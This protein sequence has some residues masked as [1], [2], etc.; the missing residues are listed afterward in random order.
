MDTINP[1]PQKIWTVFSDFKKWTGEPYHT[2]HPPPNSCVCDLVLK[3]VQD[4]SEPVPQMAY[5]WFVA[6]RKKATDGKTVKPII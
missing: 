1:F 5:K 6:R 3:K 2:P 4:D